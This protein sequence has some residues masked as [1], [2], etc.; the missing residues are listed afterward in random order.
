MQSLTAKLFALPSE[1]APVGRIAQLPAPTT[2]LP[3]EKPLPKPRP[4]TKWEVFAQRKGI[5][6]Q[7][8]SKL[9]WDENS[10]EWRRRYGYKKAGDEKEIPV[11]EAGPNDEVCHAVKMSRQE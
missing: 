4:P 9:E 8:R 11:V 10:K 7:K 3:R 5:V 6:K 1:P 2:A